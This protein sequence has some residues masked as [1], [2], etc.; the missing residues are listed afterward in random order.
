MGQIALACVFAT[1]W[2]IDTFWVKWTTF[3]NRLIPMG[4]RIACALILFALAYVLASGGLSVV[5][6]KGTRQAGVIKTGV[7]G[8]VRHPIYLGELLL[9]LGFLAFS[10]SL[11]GAVVWF[12]A[13]V[14]L[15]VISRY[16]ERL[17]L[18]RFGAEYG[19]YMRR[20]PMWI[21]RVRWG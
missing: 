4:I 8:V 18:E 16:E 7:F 17:L 14:F 10:L 6:G 3:L 9:Y 1:V 15:H 2:A 21:P 11:A 19:G 12:S 20:V 13:A 5:F